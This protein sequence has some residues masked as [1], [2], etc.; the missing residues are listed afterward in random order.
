MKKY[1]IKVRETL[2]RVVIVE[3]DDYLEARDKVE[4]AYYKGNL[5][6]YADNSAVDLELE[7]DTDNYIEIF[8][9]EEFKL[10][11]VSD[12]LKR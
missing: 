4:D 11:E 9:A 2:T 5:Q 12:E 6:L 10:M 3:A 8:G 7:N 1:A